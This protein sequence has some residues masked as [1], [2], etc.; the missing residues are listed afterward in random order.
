M[1]SFYSADDVWAALFLGLA[2]GSIVTLIIHS[3]YL[4]FLDRSRAISKK[5][6]KPKADR[7]PEYDPGYYSRAYFDV[8]EK[9]DDD[10]D[11]IES[12]S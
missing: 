11:E 1:R 9:D 8:Y 2:V 4:D 12:C 10:D 5:K 6:A 7:E 3:I